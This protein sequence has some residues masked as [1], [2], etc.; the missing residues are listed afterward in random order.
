MKTAQKRK[1]DEAARKLLGDLTNKQ[2]DEIGVMLGMSNLGCDKF[3]HP[4][5]VAESDGMYDMMME[6]I[7]HWQNQLRD[8]REKWGWCTDLEEMATEARKRRPG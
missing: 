6:E 8:P 4:Q 7:H 1:D 5:C 2:L 3:D